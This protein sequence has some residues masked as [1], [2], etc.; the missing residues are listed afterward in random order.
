MGYRKLMKSVIVNFPKFRSGL[1]TRMD[2]R[3]K[4]TTAPPKSASVA[5]MP[6]A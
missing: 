3:G 4:P 5:G 1:A 6:W 2:A